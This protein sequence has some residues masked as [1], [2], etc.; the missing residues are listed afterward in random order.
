MLNRICISLAILIISP[1]NAR[2]V[3]IINL[4]DFG[5]VRDLWN[6]SE[7]GNI[8]AV[9]IGTGTQ[10]IAG[11]WSN[12]SG[13]QVLGTLPGGNSSSSY[14][15]SPDGKY[16][17]GTSNTPN[18][19]RGFVWSATTGMQEIGVLPGKTISSVSAISNNGNVIVG[20]SSSG[21]FNTASA[22]IQSQ[23][24]GL[25][26][27]DST[28]NIASSIAQALS[29]NGNYIAGY[30]TI[31]GINRAIRWDTTGQFINLGVLPGFQHSFSYDVSADGNI[32][33][34]LCSGGPGS[35]NS[36]FVW[37]ATEGMRDAGIVGSNT[38]F[39]GLSSDGKVAVG[40]DYSLDKAII[41][42]DET[43]QTRYLYDFLLTKSIP[44]FSD[45]S[46]LTYTRNISGTATTGYNITGSGYYKGQPSPFLIRGL[47]SV[48][49]PSTYILGSFAAGL[50]AII[51]C[52]SRNT[53]M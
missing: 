23:N 3:D 17:C 38:R 25:T 41:W 32:M 49:E 22:F 34:G 13:L 15:L 36:A 4:R 5:A 30:G 19:D 50:I 26:S 6:V 8:V 2:A 16:I 12:N 10:R 28:G 1:F 42:D 29:D 18:G 52:C 21:P 24:S 53:K 47:T 51:G 20:V 44:G 33:V 31:S 37:S 39:F 9:E 27:L 14:G 40:W 35:S 45:W 46:S 7:D 11:F 48:P 43:K